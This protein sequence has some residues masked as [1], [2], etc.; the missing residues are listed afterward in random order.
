MLRRRPR[1]R[2]IIRA[3]VTAIV[4]LGTCATTAWS[5]AVASAFDV[6]AENALPGTANWQLKTRQYNRDTEAYL[7]KASALAGESIDLFARCKADTFVVTAL[8]MGFYQGTG[9]RRIYKSEPVTC[10]R[11]VG[12]DTDTKTGLIRATWSPSLT[13]DTTAWPEGAYLLKVV[14]SDNSGTYINFIVRSASN[15]DRVVFVSAHMTFQAYNMWGGASTYRGTG[16][17]STRARAVSFDRPQSKTLGTSKFLGYELPLIRR[18]E[19]L[20]IP[21][22]YLADVDIALNPSLID[23]A[24]TLLFGGHIEYWTQEERDAV[25]AARSNGTNLIFFGANTAYWRVRLEKSPLGPGRTLIVYKSAASDP[26][27]KQ[28][29]ILFRS[30]GQSEADLT[31]GTYR[32]FPARGDFTVTRAD[33]WIFAGTGATNGSTYD[34][35]LGPEV[36]GASASTPN[37]KIIA[38]SFTR[39]GEKIKTYASFS[40]MTHASGARTVN[41]GTM[42]WV[43]RGFKATTSLRTREFV[44]RVTDNLLTAATRPKLGH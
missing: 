6:A 39:C 15:V 40:I 5:P 18:A 30:T 13:M 43:L 2:T 8:R 22:S 44:Q 35:I 1:F 29:T 20:G 23:G 41:V 3:T 21:I 25:M 16:G 17:F 7:N 32:C 11:Q 12:R 10:E 42:G 34:E 24:T 14:A 33:H 4:L 9:A 31:G 28:P 38:S 36:D 27:K 19:A 26:N 37:L